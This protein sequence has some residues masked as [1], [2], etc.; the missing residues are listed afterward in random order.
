MI[1]PRL[2]EL[3]DRYKNAHGVSEAELARRIGVSRENLRKWRI[4]GVRRLPDR[5]NLTAVARVIGR[6]YREVLSAALFD[7]E[8]LT[9]DQAAIPRPYG[10]VLH[11]AIS[12]LT[13]ASRLTNQPMRQSSSGQWEADPDPRAALQIDWGA[14]VTEALAG[15]AANVGSIEQ[16]LAGRPGSWEADMVRQALRASAFDSKDLL[17]H[18]TEPVVVD[19]WVE[20]VLATTADTTEEDYEAAGTELHN[21]YAAVPEPDDLPTEP[22]PFSVDDPRIAAISWISVDNG[23]LVIAPF[24]DWPEGFEQHM[25]VAQDLQEEANNSRPDTLGEIAY[26]KA[27]DDLDRIGEALAEQKRSD[28]TAYGAQLAAAIEDGLRDLELTVPIIVRV[29]PAPEGWYSR[30][31]RPAHQPPEEPGNDI[32]A[33]ILDA[34]MLTPTPSTPGAET[35]PG[36]LLERAEASLLRVSEG[37]PLLSDTDQTKLSDQ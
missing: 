21:R 13:E 4:N 29:T 25:E 17:R 26:N 6:P 22:G 19:L 16:I 37:T 23:N 24:A 20:E 2:V 15:A 1:T 11:D 9:D 31:D 27:I 33:A 8:Y 34:I 7:T 35:L 10:E 32:D 3:I 12:V 36:R 30:D 18:R 5:A 28:Y 14:F